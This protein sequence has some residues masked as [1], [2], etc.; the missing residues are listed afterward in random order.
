MLR[1]LMRPFKTLLSS[2]IIFLFFYMLY[3]SLSEEFEAWIPV[4]TSSRSAALLKVFAVCMSRQSQ[5]L[6][7]SDVGIFIVHVWCATQTRPRFNVPSERR[8]TTT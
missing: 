4:P 7:L 5:I 3:C 8:G 2:L 1:W 6:F